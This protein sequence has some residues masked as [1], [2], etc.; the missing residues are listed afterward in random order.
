MSKKLLVLCLS[1]ATYFCTTVFSQQL[2]QPANDAEQITNIY[3]VTPRAG[4]QHLDL[5]ENW[6]LGWRDDSNKNLSDLETVKD[7][8][9]VERPT[10]V[11]VALFKAGKLPDPYKNQNIK[12][13]K[14]A[15]QKVWFYKKTF[16]V[17]KPE[18]DGFAF[19]SF[20]G[21][22]YCSC[23]WLNGKALGK[24]EG[25]FGGPEFEVSQL[26]NFDKPNEL[27]V[28]VASVSYGNPNYSS[29]NPERFIK[30]WGTSGG[31]GLALD[32]YFTFGMWRGVRLDFT[33][34]THLERPFIYTEKI[35]NDHSEATLIVKTEI[36]SGKHSLQHKLHAWH[37]HQ[38]SNPSSLL[39]KTN[40]K[41]ELKVRLVHKNQTQEESFSIQIPEGRSWH[42][43]RI[44]VKN[45][46]LW[47]P[48]GLGKP[49][50]YRCELELL[51]NDQPIDKIATNI[52]IRTI[53]WTESAGQR[54]SERWGN[55]QCVVNGSPIF[56]KGVNWMPGNC[57]FLLPPEPGNKSSAPYFYFNY[58][59]HECL[60]KD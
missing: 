39:K 55:W 49:N 7:W 60:R 29:R 1:V 57:L 58:E 6:Q 34:K 9:N 25:M 28:T 14:W 53:N 22:D 44:I 15:E 48:N 42:K 52:G 16:T 36:F 12:Q 46:A 32:P 33:E 10:S 51:E 27:I 4:S 47:S 19:L 20:D 56:V 37:D 35:S 26:L 11:P 45:P 50:L 30:P 38:L 2:P 23:V 54:I 31:Y 8:I 17:S 5:S 18:K 43:H 59:N 3:V 40:R 24:H 21:L 13:H 41:T